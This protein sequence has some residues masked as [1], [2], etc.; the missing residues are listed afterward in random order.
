[1]D[2]LKKAYGVYEM[3]STRYPWRLGVPKNLRERIA[4]AASKIPCI[5]YNRP[6]E[7]KEPE[8]KPKAYIKRRVK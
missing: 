1:M 2:N 7:P 5:N 3:H 4:D 8:V 6:E